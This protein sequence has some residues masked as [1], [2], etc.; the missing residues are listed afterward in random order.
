MGTGL[1]A[2]AGGGVDEWQGWRRVSQLGVRARPRRAG[3]L[4]SPPLA[5]GTAPAPPPPA[6]WL[7]QAPV[8]TTAGRVAAG[9]TR[10]MRAAGRGAQPTQALLLLLLLPLAG[11]RSWAAASPPAPPLFNVSLDAA[12]ELRWLPVLRHYDPVLVRAAVVQIVG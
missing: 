9:R 3:S 5:L 12:P 2:G 11:V 4:Q 1:R 6:S 8:A 7:P 10:T